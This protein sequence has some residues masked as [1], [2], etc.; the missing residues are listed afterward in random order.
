[1]TYDESS[2]TNECYPIKKGQPQ[3]NKDPSLIFGSIVTKGFC[4]MLVTAVGVNSFNSKTRT[5]LGAAS[6]DSQ[7]QYTTFQSLVSA[8]EGSLLA[9]VMALTFSMIKILRE[10]S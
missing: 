3:E 2:I 4:T 10:N 5:G 9:L 7:L 8:P 1:M 6:E